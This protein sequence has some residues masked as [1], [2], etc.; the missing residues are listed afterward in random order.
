MHRHFR[1]RERSLFDAGARR[2]LGG[3]NPRRLQSRDRRQRLGQ[4]SHAERSN[5]DSSGQ[6]LTG[7]GHAIIDLK[8]GRSESDL[9]DGSGQRRQR[10][11]RNQCL[12]ERHVGD[13]SRCSKAATPLAL[14]I[15]DAYRNCAANGGSPTAAAPTIVESTARR[16]KR[17]ATYDVL[18]IT[19]KGGK[20]F[21]AWFDAKTHLLAKT[22][23]KQSS[24]TVTIRCPIIAPSTA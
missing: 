11:R 8:N 18:T 4:Q 22:V 14:A 15:N 2:T 9:Q 12:A 1:I 3:R 10:L 5:S 20:P 24:Q 21:D 23:E 16:P 13:R 6:G 19:P 17:G 7:T